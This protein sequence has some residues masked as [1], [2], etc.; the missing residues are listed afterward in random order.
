MPAVMVLV[1]IM[2]AVWGD[3]DDWRLVDELLSFRLPHA[4][5]VRHQEQVPAS[6]GQ[7]AEPQGQ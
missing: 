1:V 6:D 3:P 4:G 5:F 7:V 2:N